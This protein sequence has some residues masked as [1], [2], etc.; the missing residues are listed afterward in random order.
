MDARTP[1][2]LD[3]GNAGASLG[4]MAVGEV[5][6]TPDGMFTF[7][8]PGGLPDDGTIVLRVTV[9]SGSHSDVDF[10]RLQVNPTYLTT[11]LNRIQATF[12]SVGN[13]GYNGSNLR[14]GIGF[15]YDTTHSILYQGG[16]LIGTSADRLSDVARVSDSP[17]EGT[18]D[19]F[20]IVEPFRITTATDSS[21]QIGRARFDDAGRG[22]QRVGVDVTMTTYEY[23]ESP[24]DNC[25][26][27]IFDVKNVTQSALQGLH[28]GLY[29][30]WDVDVIESDN[31]AA[32]Q[33]SGGFGYV[34]NVFDPASYYAGTAL[35]SDQTVDFYGIDNNDPTDGVGIF[36]PDKKWR[37]LS[38]GIGV[39]PTGVTDVSIMLGGGP[40]TIEAGQSMKFAFALMGAR[41]LESLATTT[42]AA[43]DRYHAL[44]G[45]TQEATPAASTLY[46]R[47]NPFATRTTISFDLADAG[48]VTLRLYDLKGAL[49]GTPFDGALEIGP[50]QLAIDGAGLA[51]GAYLYELKTPAGVMHGR[52]LK[53]GQ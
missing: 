53:L 40:V 24:L 13:I 38:G 22:A 44:A 42:S 32:Y 46:V 52:I 48:E 51:E 15:K 28:C 5:K 19:G 18:A 29:L 43:R 49:V 45:V 50:H 3:I 12:N 33:S 25:V 20:R 8:V 14:Q 41:S 6:Q 30:D 26:I 36:S 23:R 1:G 31:R 21:V 10:I 35:L 4:A 47:P 11:D 39:N 17:S 27:V 34:T 7:T 37:M 16:L 9:T 2:A